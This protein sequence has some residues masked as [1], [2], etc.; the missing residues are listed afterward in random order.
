LDGAPAPSAA[1]RAP[2]ML[3]DHEPDARQPWERMLPVEEWS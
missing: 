3:D 2:S 1:Q